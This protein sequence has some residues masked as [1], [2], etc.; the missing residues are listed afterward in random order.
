M[1]VKEALKESKNYNILFAP[2]IKPTENSINPN[3]SVLYAI[4]A[5]VSFMGNDE[6]LKI[7]QFKTKNKLSGIVVITSERILFCNGAFGIGTNKSIFLNDIQSVD[8]K[9]NMLS[10]K[11]RIKGITETLIID[12]N[13]K[14]MKIFKEK[15]TSA[16]SNVKNQNS[17]ANTKNASSADEILKYKNLLDVGAITQEEF[18]LKKKELLGL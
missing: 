15:L 6:A 13:S 1:T 14:T 17:S 16:M 2:Y 10:S 9:S 8:D 5:N 18:D 11:L 7:D 4:T 12:I 3:E